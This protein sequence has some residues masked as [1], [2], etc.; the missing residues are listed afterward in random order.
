MLQQSSETIRVVQSS[1]F[2]KKKKGM[3]N[4]IFSQFYNMLQF[5]KFIFKRKLFFFFIN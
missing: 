1:A 2:Y 3:H 4:E 5:V